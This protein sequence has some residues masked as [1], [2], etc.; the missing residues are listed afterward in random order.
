MMIDPLV[1]ESKQGTALMKSAT[2]PGI[3]LS[4]S[5]SEVV[6]D[7]IISHQDHSA[8]H[9]L[10]ALRRHALDAYRQVPNATKALV[11]ADALGHQAYLN[12]WGYL[13]P[14]GS[15][16]GEAAQTLLQL[17][18]DA[19]PPLIPLLDDSRPASLFGSEQAALNSMYNYRRKDFAY[20]YLALL[21]GRQPAFDA[22]PRARDAEIERFKSSVLKARTQS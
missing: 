14:S 8:Y 3:K 10:F 20:R 1:A 2:L 19:L 15:H 18:H 5:D 11:S 12:D 21:M 16:D 13:D 6:R 17:G 9:L 4:S 7:Y 22:D